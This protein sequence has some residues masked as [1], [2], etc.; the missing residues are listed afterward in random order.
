[1]VAPIITH[2]IGI[3]ALLAI[4]MIIIMYVGFM[5]QTMMY[6]NIK[7]NLELVSQSLAFT[8]G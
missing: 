4:M 1:M 8:M 6:E 5:T 2:V 7:K 3:T